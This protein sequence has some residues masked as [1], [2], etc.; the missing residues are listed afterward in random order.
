[1]ETYFATMTKAILSSEFKANLESS[2]YFWNKFVL[3]SIGF[4]QK[5]NH[6][7]V[8]S[9]FEEF[10]KIYHKSIKTYRK[11]ASESEFEILF[12]CFS[13]LV[14]SNISFSNSVLFPN[15]DIQMIKSK[16]EIVLLL[17]GKYFKLLPD[18]LSQCFDIN[19]G[20]Y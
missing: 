8:D 11:L 19:F 20:F 2:R 4:L 9:K 12:D 13:D 14:L 5:L 16:L 10:G 1:M 18:N 6:Q 3:L 15:Q 7:M 17:D